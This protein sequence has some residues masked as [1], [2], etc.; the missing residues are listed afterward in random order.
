MAETIL[1]CV[2]IT[3]S[4]CVGDVEWRNHH[5]E[6]DRIVNKP[7]CSRHWEERVDEQE[8]IEATYH[9]MSDSAPSWLREDDIGERWEED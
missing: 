6:M 4:V 1:S 5:W 2:N 7:Y 9:V 3:K 8:R